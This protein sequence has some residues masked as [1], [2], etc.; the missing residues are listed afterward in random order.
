M[1]KRIEN[2]LRDIIGRPPHRDLVVFIKEDIDNGGEIPTTIEQIVLRGYSTTR[3]MEDPTNTLSMFYPSY[4]RDGISSDPDICRATLIHMGSRYLQVTGNTPHPMFGSIRSMQ[5]HHNIT[6]HYIE[7]EEC[8]N[9]FAWLEDSDDESS[10]E[11][12]NYP[13]DIGSLKVIEYDGVD[14]DDQCGVCQEPFKED[15]KLFKLE[16]GHMFHSTTAECIGDTSVRTWFNSNN[17]CPMCRHKL[18]PIPSHMNPILPGVHGYSIKTPPFMRIN[19]EPFHVSKSRKTERIV[20]SIVNI[21]DNPESKEEL[22]SWYQVR[23]NNDENIQT[24]RLD[25]SCAIIVVLLG[26]TISVT[27]NLPNF[28]SRRFIFQ[29]E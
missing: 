21:S 5:R 25:Q 29:Y 4:I 13:A 2:I 11:E 27:S 22:D 24:R 14:S 8:V 28:D 17:T 3:L 20:C 1:S 26:A 9:N 12:E 10:E 18:P 19:R 23:I 7:S 6:G 15:Q 16:C